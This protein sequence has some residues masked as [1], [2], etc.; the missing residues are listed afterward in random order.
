MPCLLALKGGKAPSRATLCSWSDGPSLGGSHLAGPLD[1]NCLRH[2]GGWDEGTLLARIRALAQPSWGD[3]VTRGGASEIRTPHG[4][5]AR[6]RT[7]TPA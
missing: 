2:L 4:F 3:T 7:P 5:W 6:A 1:P